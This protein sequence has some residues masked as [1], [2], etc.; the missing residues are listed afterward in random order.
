MTG[1]KPSKGNVE[2]KLTS[3]SGRTAGDTGR[4]RTGRH[5]SGC[6][7]LNKQAVALNGSGEIARSCDTNVSVGV[8]VTAASADDGSQ[9]WQNER[10][11]SGGNKLRRVNSC[12]PAPLNPCG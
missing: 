8:G 9:L 4:T 6:D 11:F 1:L 7:D 12:C 3:M 2:P 10:R 5:A